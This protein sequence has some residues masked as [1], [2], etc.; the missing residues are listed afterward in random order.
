MP[1]ADPKLRKS[2]DELNFKP[3]PSPIFP[4][5]YEPEP[6]VYKEVDTNHFVLQGNWGDFD[7]E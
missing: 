1:V 6:S 7:N 5:D 3:I 2:N 4:L